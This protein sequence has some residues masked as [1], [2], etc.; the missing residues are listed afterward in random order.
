[1]STPVSRIPTAPVRSPL[2]ICAVALMGSAASA[3]PV[4]RP[5]FAVAAIKPSASDT[6]RSIKFLPG[7]R[8]VA[9]GANVRLLIKVAYNLNDDQV[10]GGPSWIGMKRFDIDAKPDAPTGDAPTS[11]DAAAV[12]DADKT[13]VQDVTHLRLQALLEDRF[14]LKLRS[15]MKEMNTYALV[16]AKSGPKLT[17]AADPAAAPHF[18]GSSGALVATSASMDQLAGA[19]S[20]WVGHPVLNFTGIGGRYD[21][22]LTWSP[23]QPVQWAMPG[24]SLS[25]PPPSQDTGGPTIFTALQ[26]QLGLSLQSRKAKTLFETVENVQLPSEN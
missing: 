16:V 9:T 14:H 10:S 25:A 1:M 4:A 3:Q 22:R 23:D 19:M 20:D 17:K 6:G 2:A 8:F 5:T 15:E 21:F 18:Q 26:Q 11:T 13:R 7:G 24:G 12:S